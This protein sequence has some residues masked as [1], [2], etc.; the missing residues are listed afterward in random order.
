MHG[1]RCLDKVEAA[2]LNRPRGSA[3]FCALRI[4]ATIKN[5]YATIYSLASMTRF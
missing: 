4:D 5:Q 2:D 1:R 3:R